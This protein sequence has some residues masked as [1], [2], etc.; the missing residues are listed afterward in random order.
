MKSNILELIKEQKNFYAK[1][2]QECYNFG[3]LGAK[4]ENLNDPIFKEAYHKC[5]ALH[6]LLLLIKEKNML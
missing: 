2:A 6:D 4:K 3:L 5:I 1:Q